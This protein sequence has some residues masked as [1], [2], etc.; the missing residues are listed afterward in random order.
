MQIVITMAGLGSRFRSVG[1]TVPK[2]MIEVNG[3]SLLHWSLLSLDDFKGSEYYFIVRK[4]DRAKAY[5]SRCCSAIGIK[6]FTIIEI[7]Y[8]TSG[9]AETVLF[10]QEY[11]DNSDELLIYNIDT[12]VEPGYILSST[13]KGDGFIPCFNGVG[14]HWS[15]VELDES[16]KACKVTE[17]VRISNNCTIG[18]YYFKTCSL[19]S[20]LYQSYYESNQMSCYPEKYVAPLYNQLIGDGGSVFISLIPSNRVHVLGTPEEVIEFQNKITV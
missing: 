11:W 13:L 3:K 9:Q 8:L 14:D 19:Y 2:Y 17:K 12:Y 6:S 5:V 18:A 4:E 16:G 10:A 7:D 20:Q 1:F 15:F